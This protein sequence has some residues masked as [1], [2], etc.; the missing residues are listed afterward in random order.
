MSTDFLFGSEK[1]SMEIWE[2]RIVIPFVGIREF[3][4]TAGRPESM[5]IGLKKFLCQF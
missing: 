5:L 1:K 3:F 2:G 4:N